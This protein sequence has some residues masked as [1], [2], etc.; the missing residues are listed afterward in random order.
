MSDAS[1]RPTQRIVGPMIKPVENQL[2][3]ALSCIG[4][5]FRENE[6]AYLALTQK[7]E[8]V[9]RDRVA[10]ALHRALSK[11]S[12]EL[13]VCR[14]WKRID[15][16]V[17]DGGAPL[18]LVETKA[19]YSFDLLN[20]DFVKTYLGPMGLV[21]KDIKKACDTAAK[22]AGRDCLSSASFYSL[23]FCINP[24]VLSDNKFCH[25]IKYFN[26]MRNYHNGKQKLKYS[27]A[28]RL[29]CGE[30]KKLQLAYGGKIKAGKAF[31]VE[32]ELFQWL[33]HSG[34]QFTR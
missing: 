25:C 4:Q 14:E 15:L 29:V 9:L 26:K 16:A 27:H 20:K 13:R 28:T 2:T 6:L 34:P 3:K 1:S 22:H 5:E 7:P 12:Q 18:V 11:N 30:L 10:F 21:A 19:F 17:L 31:D 33:F 32:V 24:L 23:I 8:H